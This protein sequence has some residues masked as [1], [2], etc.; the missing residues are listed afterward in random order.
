MALVLGDLHGKDDVVVRMHSECMTSEVFGSLKCDC[1]EQLDV[2]MAAIAHAGAGAILYYTAAGGVAAIGAPPTRSARTPL[3]SDGHD[4]VDANRL[5]GPGLPDDARRY[6]A[7][8]DMLVYLGVGSVRLMTNNP[9]K[10]RSLEALGVRV[11]GR[12]SPSWSRRTNT[13]ARYLERPSASAWSTTCP[14]AAHAAAL[15]PNSRA[16][17]VEGQ[18][19]R[20]ALTYNLRVTDSEEEAE[21]DPPDTI[22][23]IERAL[24]RVGHRVEPLDVTGP[25]SLLVTRLEA[26]APDMIFNLAEGHRGKTRRAF[27]SALFEELGIPSTGSDA[28]TLCVTLDKAL[29]KKQLAG[30]GV[31]SPRGR[32]VTRASLQGGGLDELPFPVIVKPNFEGSSKGI[33][34]DSVVEDPIALGRV[35][36]ELL[37]RYPDGALVER[38]VPGTDVRMVLVEGLPPLP[39]VETIV[40]P[41]YPR[42]VD[43]FDY[44]LANV[45]TRFVERRAPARLAQG[46]EGRLR[47]LAERTLAAFAMR[48]VAALSFRVT[49]DGE[50]WFLSTTAIPSFD[51]AGALFAATR[52]VGVDYDATVLA[53]LRSA[54]KRHGLTAMLDAT[55][56]RPPRGRR[57]SLRVGLAFNMKR[58]DSHGGDDR[59]AEYDAPETIQAITQ[60]IESH[61]HVVVPL[62]ANQ[63]FPR[64]LM[65]SQPDV[66][67]NIA[68][69]MS[70]RSREAQV[71]SLCELRGIDYTGSDSATSPRC[72]RQGAV[73]AP[74]AWLI[75]TPAFQVLTTG[76][77]KVRPFR[78]PVIVKPNQEGTSKGITKK[79]VCDDEARLREV[80]RELIERY[81]QPALVEEYI[82]GRELTVGLL[83]ERRPRVLPPMEVVFMTQTDRPV[84]DY[85]CKQHWQSHVRYECPANLTKEELRAVE[86]ACRSTFM[87]LGCRDVARVDVRLAADGRVYVL[88]VNPLPGLTPD[89]SDLCLI[90]NGAKID[91][92]TLIGEIL[93]G[94]IKRWQQRQRVGSKVEETAGAV[95]VERDAGA[96]DAAPN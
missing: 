50:I 95:P 94:A 89:Y 32:F 57:T 47:V 20:I 35:L 21:F 52:A 96:P 18:G 60:A 41:D 24:V 11:S 36:D 61:G 39:P 38:Y 69:G 12:T 3:Q 4:T 42:R 80:A 26:F 31:P 71:P 59:E 6:D 66:V 17:Q 9:D 5:L 1:K 55:K 65:A 46:V 68:E 88:E 49:P 70:G 14:R 58:I 30:W 53:I 51:P 82:V 40:D 56:P 84:Y 54:A 34:Q 62:E 85:E 45:D 27:Y 64:A 2:A 8:R 78:Y 77:E 93:S 44:R 19:M 13:P 16:Q 28:Y 79:S 81:R 91:Y 63:E 86:K 92:R 76:R 75:D 73:Q 25:A 10:T 7:A 15:T 23:G 48:D 43:V 72:T 37:G 33:G 29:T 67:F 74:A 90:A 87:A 83:G 22:A